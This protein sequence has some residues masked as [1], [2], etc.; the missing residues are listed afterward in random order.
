MQGRL[1]Q[2]A[3]QKRD[4]MFASNNPRR[5][6]SC[7]HKTEGSS[8]L[9]DGNLVTDPAIVLDKWVDHFSKLGESLCSSDPSL[10]DVYEIE[11]ATFLEDDYVL[12]SPFVVEEIEVSLNSSFE[13]R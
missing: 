2:I 13:E 9:I 7:S 10:L 3:I 8:L 11:V 6:R 4:E 5:F 1:E 12:N